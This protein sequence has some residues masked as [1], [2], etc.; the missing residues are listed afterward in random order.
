MMQARE[1]DITL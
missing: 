1:E